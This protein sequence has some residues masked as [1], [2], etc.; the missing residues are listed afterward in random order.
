V[1]NG[2]GSELKPGWTAEI[3]KAILLPDY[4][5][6]EFSDVTNWDKPVYVEVTVVKDET[7]EATGT[8]IRHT[9]SLQVTIEPA[10]AV[11]AGAK[12]RRVGTETWLD[13]GETETYVDT[14]VYIVEFSEIATWDKPANLEVTIAKD[15]LAEATGTY[16]RHTGSLKV[17]IEPVE[18]VAAGA[19]WRRAGTTNW[20]DSEYTEAGIPVGFHIVEFKAL[21]G[22][23]TARITG[24]SVSKDQTAEVVGAYVTSE[25]GSVVAWGRNDYGQCNVPSPNSGYIAVAGGSRHSL[26]LKADGSIVAWG[27][28]DYGQCSVPIPNAGFIAVAGGG[29]H[30]LGL[31]PDG[32][33]VAW[34]WNNYGQCNIPSPNTGF[35]AVAAGSY[36]SLGLKSD[37]SVVAWGQNDHGQCNVPSPNT[38]FIAVA[39]GEYH[40]LGLKSDGSIVAWG[41]NGS[42]QCN[43][44]EPN[45]GFI[46]VAGGAHHSLGLKADGSI[47]AWGSNGSGQCNVPSPNSGFIAVAGVYNHSLGLKSDGSIVAWGWN[48][49]GQCEVPEPNTGFIA[50]AAGPYHS[51]GIRPAGS[52]QVTIEPAEVVTAGA[53]WRRVGTETWLDSG[54]IEGNLTPGL[55]TVEFSDVTNWDKPVYVEVTVVKD[56]TTEAT[57]TYIRH[58][59]SLQVTIQPAEAVTSGAKWRRVGT[60]TWLDSGETETYVDTE[61]YAVEFS[62]IAGWDKSAD[63]EVTIAKDELAEATGT[64]IRHT[65]SLKVT[66]EPVEAVAA[67]AKWR[68]AGTTNWYDSE[69]TEA[70]IPVGFHIVEF[71]A[72]DGWV[73]AR[74]TGIDIR[75]D[76]TELLAGIY[77]ESDSVV[78]WG[79]NIYDQCNVPTPNS[80]FIAVAAGSAHNLGLKFDGTIVAWGDNASGQCNVPSPNSGFIG[81]AGGGYHSL[82]LK[83]DGKVVAWGYNTAG[84]CN[85]PSPNAGFVAVAA[86]LYH[87]LGL[88]SD[89]SIVAWGWNEYGQC[90]VP[91]PNT[92]FVAVAGVHYHSLGVKSDGSIVAWGYNNFGQCN[93]PEPNN[94]FVA[95]ATGQYHSLGLKS[96][97][98]IIAWGSN[99][100]GQCEVPEP[101]T[102]FV[103]VAAGELYSLGLKTDG[104]IVAWGRNDYGQCEV[105]EPNTNFAAVSAGNYHALGIRPAG[106]LQV[107]IQPAE[108]VAD[109]AKWRRVGTETWLDS[110]YTEEGLYPGA[111]SVEFVELVSWD[112]PV[113]TEVTIVKYEMTEA[114]GVYIRQTSLRVTIQPAEAVADGAKWRRV[115]TETWLDSGDTEGN[116]APGSGVVEFSRIEG[117]DTPEDVDVT[118]IDGQL[119]ECSGTYVWN[120]GSLQV[121]IQP[122]EAVTAGAKWRRV[123]TE[124]WQ[125]SGYIETN[126]NPGLYNVEFVE[127]AGWDK[128]AA[129]DVTV[130]REETTEAMG[131]YL[132]HTGSLQVTI[133]PAEPVTAG[134]K[135]RRSGTTNWLDSECVEE[136]VPVGFCI[137][138]FRFINGWITAGMTGIDISKDQTEHLTGTYAEPES[139]VAWG[140]NY[141]GQ[142]NVPSPNSGFIAVAGGYW[143]SLG[144][145][146]NGSIVAWGYNG[147]GECN[148]PS[149]NSGFIAVAGGGHHS[150]GLKS[151]GSIVAWGYNGYGE[152]NVP[153]PNSGFIAV[154]GGDYHSLGLKSDGSIMALGRNDYGQC[155]VPSPN[156]GFVAIAGRGFHSL[157]LKSDGSI[158]AWGNNQYYQCNVPSPNTGFVAVAAGGAHSLGLKSDGSIVAW[159]SNGSGQ[160]NVPSPNSG[161]IAVS[162]GGNHSLGLKLDGS[163]VA[164]GWNGQGQCNVPSPNS[165]F[166]AVAGGGQHSLG[167]RDITPPHF[168]SIDA[169]PSPAK[170]ETDVTITFT[171]SEVLKTY[172]TVTVNGNAA[173]FFSKDDKFYTYTY[174]IQLSDPDGAATIYISGTD[175][176]GNPGEVTNTTA[177]IIDKTAPT[178]ETIFATPKTWTN[179]NIIELSFSAEDETSGIDYYELSLDGGQFF[180]ATSPYYWNVGTVTDGEYIVVVRAVDN[181]GNTATAQTI[182]YLDK[183]PPVIAI[184]SAEQLEVELIGG[185]NAIQGVIQI[186]V[187]ATDAHSGIAEAPT[188]TVIPFGGN[189]ETATH[190]GQVDDTFYFEWTVTTTTPNGEAQIRSSVSDNAG[191]E[192]EAV[193]RSIN[194]N[195]AQAVVEVELLGVNVNVTRTIKFVIGGNEE[196]ERII[197][198]K[199]VT[200]ISGVGT[201]T[202]TDLPDLGNW[203][204]LSGKDEQHTLCHTVSLDVDDNQ[205]YSASLELRGGDAT[206]DNLIDIKD[207]GLMAGQW[208]TIPD[209]DSTWPLRNAN[210]DCFGT[211][212]TSDFVFIQ[213]GFLKWGDEEPVGTE[214]DGGVGTASTTASEQPDRLTPITSISVEE[215]AEIIGLENAIKADFNQDGIVDTADIKWFIEYL[216]R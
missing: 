142:C 147:Y 214:P 60:E 4:I 183:T 38:G 160:C 178:D 63:L 117:W 134:A 36:H 110:G 21:A 170:L 9:G 136:G 3:L 155:N 120:T 81:V 11:T 146:L 122:A 33:I 152:C 24:A 121:T 161:F 154:A 194:V 208:G 109:G 173:T 133:E 176:A 17:T 101:N 6:F 35:I 25:P 210:F 64:Y 57:G 105:P 29:F 91:S 198:Y 32:S 187:T 185:P 138:E 206:N 1:L 87:S 123:G 48:Y 100:R 19:K 144:L 165:G 67:G 92:G 54:D 114:S 182:V 41:N 156:T 181:A 132:R 197:L 47:V 215:L 193:S 179:V 86:G 72:I 207:F 85:V 104:S 7:T 189:P 125:D 199:P 119:I 113:N 26:G 70:G 186:A 177:L 157:G 20:Y 88:K 174:T 34:G 171:A 82:G 59:G 95:V 53:K 58:T 108:S 37:G 15:E 22:W 143:H 148:V 102:G 111:Y 12:W 5:R 89:G 172:P 195:K 79:W 192:A 14:G 190:T 188:V 27:Y 13:S 112:K 94:G 137:V 162:G 128:P 62:E 84:Q 145:K 139:I 93:V 153:S 28:N 159:G 180:S 99:Y 175:L 135:W 103:A 209:P 56:E 201:A 51:L 78:A 140:R 43:V 55:Y 115:G 97:G 168:V 18:A 80:G 184:D 75:K 204:Q 96:D 118:L 150:L 76:Q 23:V 203:G 141:Y 167:I 107:T 39:G 216:A 130:I 90:N 77:A 61:V 166:I 106:S 46:A 10:E 169:D 49:F 8:Y 16:I 98:S 40:S 52:L 191:N 212:W 31:K 83:S 196:A 149:P 73:T 71:K 69:Y 127:L 116:L 213:Q 124:T 200:F 158:V 202:I 74:M 163:I 68:R 66:I 151:D 65:G 30:S 2:G 164:W 126:L 129:V 211:V 205:Q 131:T 45:S 42:G 50:V 44:P